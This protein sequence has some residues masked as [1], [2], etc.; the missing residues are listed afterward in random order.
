MPQGEVG[1]LVTRA[2][3]L[4]RGYWLNGGPNEAA[5]RAAFCMLDGL[6][7]FRTGDLALVDEDGYFFL[8]DRL[9]RMINVSGYKVWPVE[10]ESAL[11]AHPAVH[12]ACVIAVPDTRDG[13][14]AVSGEAVKALVVLKPERQHDVTA[15]SFIAWCREQMAVYKAPRSVE[16][17]AAL[18]KSGTGKIQWRELQ[19]AHQTPQNPE[20]SA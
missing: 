20:S 4:M 17:V 19:Q 5:D 7:Y 15:E 11:Y 8:K 9:K 18:P 12:E 2:P 10:V 3:Q 16:F 1:E 6:R 14:G 13:R